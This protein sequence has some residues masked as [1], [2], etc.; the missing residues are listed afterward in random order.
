MRRS[1]IALVMMLALAGAET[2]ASDKIDFAQSVG[3][4]LAKRC[5]SCHNGSEHQ[6]GLD[7]TRHE[8]ML[9][10]G[11]S[12]PAIVPGNAK[13][14]LIWQRIVDDEMPPQAPLKQDDRKLIRIWLDSGAAWSGGTLDPLQYTT[15]SRAGYDWWSL[16]PLKTPT[17]TATNPPT[18]N[19]IDAFVQA[20]LAQAKLAGSPPADR[21]TLIRRLHFGLLGLPPEP[22]EVERFVADAS[23]QAY[24]ALVDRLLASPAYG[25]RWA[26]HWLDVVRYGESQ[27]FERDKLRT[28]AW[29]YRDWVIDALNRDMPYDEFARLQLAGD[30]LRPGDADALI[31]TGFLVAAPYDEVGQQQQSAAMRAV[32]RQDELEDLVGT[33][34]QTFLG[35]TVNCSRCHDHKF[36]PIRQSEYY[37]LAAALAGV[38]H[39]EP[40]LP[41]DA[42]KRQSLIRAESIQARKTELEPRIAAMEAPVR[43]QILAQ[44]RARP[45]PKPKPIASWEFDD[46]LQ[47][48]VGELH[49][50]LHEGATVRGGRLILDGTGYATSAL[51]KTELK[52]KTL[53]VWVA[54]ADLE[55][56][57]AGI[58]GIHSTDNKRFDAVVYGEREARKWMSG[59]DGNSRTQSFQGSDENVVIPQTIHLAIVY[60]NNGTVKA[61]RNGQPYGK[62]YTSRGTARFSPGESYVSFGV[63]HSPPGDSQLLRGQLLRGQLLRGQLLRGQL[64]RGAID[65][66]RLYDR[67]LSAEEVAASAGVEYTAIDDAELLAALAPSQR[68][69][70]SEL[71][72]EFD[73]L[74]QQQAR[75]KDAEVYA[76]SPREPEATHILH[77]GNPGDAR[78]AVTAGGIASLQGVN[79]QFG[80]D[81]QASDADRRRRLAAW[82]ADEH[83]PLFARVLVNRLWHY[84]FGVG[85]VDT[86]NDFGFNG[87]RPSHPELLDWLAGE[88]IHSGWSIKHVQRL[89]VNSDTYRQS[90]QLRAAA[91]KIDAGNRLL[92][93]KSPQRLDAETLRDTLLALSGELD[94]S[95]GG[96]GF[97]EFTTFVRNSQ[98][99]ELQDAVGPSFARRTIY[100]TWVRSARNQMLDVFDCPD[101]S[102]KA[103]QR[104]VTTTPLQALSLLNNSFVLRTAESCAMCIRSTAGNDVRQQVVGLFQRT[105]SRAPDGDE[106]AACELMVREYGLA[107]LCRVVFNSSELLYVD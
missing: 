97:Y 20:R 83:N 44:R 28:N 23:P 13:D 43:V 32:V 4:L 76:V 15:E 74:R 39:G 38:R 79:A 26:R 67:A 51:L 66:A 54:L 78:E 21:R 85:L 22:A 34:G 73:Q 81:G 29:Q 107:A 68:G 41:A 42:L 80:L 104:A 45:R 19:P 47:D 35:L 69:E 72:F 88:L 98:F 18:H 11:E 63:R 61:Y 6:G 30:V 100:R 84:H 52:A 25:Q 8:T 16:Q 105:F 49:L 24:E 57:G 92:W 59:S 103:P 9:T 50:E 17:P 12:G 65:R 82:I 86:P 102:T 14:S 55:Q 36:D 5:A 71:R 40:K 70:W 10:G 96:P 60:T 48:A 33:V 3:L 106:L 75:L 95:L 77:R 56:R 2:I 101:P 46:N 31:A 90:S 64:L 27:G 94:S 93:R 62:S 53:E 7:L 1:F 89:I 58:L 37:R 87:G 99:Y 91:A